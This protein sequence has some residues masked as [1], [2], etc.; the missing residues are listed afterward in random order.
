MSTS[1]TRRKTTPSKPPRPIEITLVGDYANPWPNPEAEYVAYVETGGTWHPS[2]DDFGAVAEVPNVIH[3]HATEITEVSNLGRFYKAIA[4]TNHGDGKER[5]DDS[6]GR[7]NLISHGSPS[8][9]ALHGYIHSGPGPSFVILGLYPTEDAP[10][11][12][13]RS[14]MITSREIE[15]LNSEGLS[16]RDQL[17]RKFSANAELWLI[18]CDVG[19]GGVQQADGKIYSVPQSLANT[20]QVRVKAF[21]DKIWYWPKP[22]EKTRALVDRTM[23][24]VGRDGPPAKGFYTMEDLYYLDAKTKERHRLGWHMKNKATDFSPTPESDLK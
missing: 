15:Y 8:T 18:L 11:D 21:T 2:K 20:F 24:S 1:V 5:P 4:F 17:R 19:K 3:A 22:S 7:V 9:I 16:Y 13:L 10:E 12:R 23:T 14:G 6:V